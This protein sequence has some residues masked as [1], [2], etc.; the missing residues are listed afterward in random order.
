[1][2]LHPRGRPSQARLGRPRKW[3]RRSAD[4]CHPYPAGPV[5]R[6]S[7]RHGAGAPHP[8]ARVMSTMH[9]AATAISTDLDRLPGPGPERQGAHV[10][11][12]GR[13]V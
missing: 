6:G 4:G 10:R 7:Q 8:R 5:Q 12:Q 2:S 3:V 11:F 1:M 13:Q 9:W